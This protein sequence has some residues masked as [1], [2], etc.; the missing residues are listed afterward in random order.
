MIQVDLAAHHRLQ[1]HLKKL[2]MAVLWSYLSEKWNQ[3]LIS[4]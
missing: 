4:D 3:G 2:R 1:L